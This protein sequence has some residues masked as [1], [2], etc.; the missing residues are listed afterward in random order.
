[1]TDNVILNSDAETILTAMVRAGAG[2]KR[3][4]R[5]LNV[6]VPIVNAY[7]SAHRDTLYPRSG[8]PAPLALVAPVPSP[9]A[10]LPALGRQRYWKPTG[11]FK[12]FEIK[13]EF[14]TCVEIGAFT[15]HL[16]AQKCAN[17]AFGQGEIFRLVYEGTDFVAGI[18][19]KQ[20]SNEEWARVKA[21]VHP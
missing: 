6:R 9:P 5:A 14:G 3:I 1:M 8:A 16:T 12:V 15:D 13:P 2:S 20:A 11:S 19:G 4:A 17:E 18:G 21:L 7:I 10:T